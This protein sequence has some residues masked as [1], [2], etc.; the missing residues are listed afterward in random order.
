MGVE[1]VDAAVVHDD[2]AVCM[3]DGGEAMGHHDGGAALHEGLDGLK[4]RIRSSRQ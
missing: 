3:L 2:D 1:G 4:M